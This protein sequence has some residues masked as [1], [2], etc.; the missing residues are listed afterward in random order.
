VQ[1][2]SPAGRPKKADQFLLAAE[3]V[4]DFAT[5]GE[6]ADAYVT[7]CVHAGIAA[8]DVICCT[9]LGTYSRGDNHAEAVGLLKKARE[10][11]SAHRLETRLSMKTKA[12]YTY[13]PSSLAEVKRAGRAASELVEMAKRVV[14][15]S[16]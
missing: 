12:G 16:R 13:L 11:A 10:T 5:E 4:R 9:R 3:L 7:L 15:G 14:A 8:A 1:R 6:V 2:K